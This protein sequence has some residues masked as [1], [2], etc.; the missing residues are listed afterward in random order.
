MSSVRFILFEIKRVL[1]YIITDLFTLYFFIQNADKKAKTVIIKKNCDRK[2][3][4]SWI[5]TE[6]LNPH[7]VG[8]IT[9]HTSRV[10]QNT[11]HTSRVGHNTDHTSRVVRTLYTLVGMD[12][13]HL[14]YGS[15][16][17]TIALKRNVE[18]LSYPKFNKEHNG[19]F[20]Q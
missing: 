12:C 16:Q 13:T 2:S 18:I 15:E 4:I 5:L 8:Q 20:N 10:G 7:D 1:V 17:N 19:F 6:P 9:V 11:V 3:Q 14:P